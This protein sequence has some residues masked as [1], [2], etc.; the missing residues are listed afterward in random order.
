M[1]LNRHW[2]IITAILVLL[3]EGGEQLVAMP[4]LMVHWSH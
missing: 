2:V 4:V 3:L 1:S